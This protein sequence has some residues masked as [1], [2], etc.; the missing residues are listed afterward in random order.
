M[1]Q[2][3]EAFGRRLEGSGIT[4]IQWIALYYIYE[5]PLISQRELSQLMY[6]KDSSA[7]RLI[8]RL[9]RDGLVARIKS[10]VDRR[11]IQLMLT[12]EGNE[13]FEAVLDLGTSFN[14]DLT[15]NIPKEDLDIFNSVLGKM[16]A[17]VSE[18]NIIEEKEE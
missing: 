15:R 16:L 2:F 3:S 10:E 1:K 9:E 14:E 17:N 13:R 12:D 18:E 5:K 11:V 7:G 6:I 4:R 8:D